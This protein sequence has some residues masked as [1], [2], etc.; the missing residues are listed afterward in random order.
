[1]LFL[2][3]PT[4]ILVTLNV[5]IISALQENRYLV[6][7]AVWSCVANAVLDRVLMIRLGV[8]GIALSTTIVQSAVLATQVAISSVLLN[9]RLAA[10][11]V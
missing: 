10:K 4:G 6:G 1:M 5:R 8:A 7:T 9:R 2:N 3:V 11:C